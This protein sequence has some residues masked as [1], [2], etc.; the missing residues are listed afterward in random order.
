[1]GRQKQASVSPHVTSAIEYAEG[2][3]DRSIVACE[4]ARSAC[5]RFIHDL[6]RQKT[7]GFEF[8]L[9]ADAAADI[10]EVAEL[11]PHIKGEWARTGQTIK[12]EPWQQFIFVNVFGWKDA[13]GYRRFRLSYCEVG[14]K[15]AKSTITSVVG[16]YMLACDDEPGAEVYSAATNKDQA[17]IVFGDGRAMA[18]KTKGFR[19]EFGVVVNAH[20]INV[21]HTMSFFKALAADSDSLDGLNVHCALI[22]ELHAH[23]QRHVFDVL[24]SATGSRRQPLLW[25]ITTAGFNR[26]GVCYEQRSYIVK[27]LNGTIVDENV[28]GIIYTLDDDDDWQDEKN[29]PKPN[30]N[31]GV[32]VYIEDLR[33]QARRAA[34]SAAMQN[35]FLTK[36]MNVWVNADTAWMNM[37]SWKQCG[38]EIKLEELKGR[39]AVLGLDLASKKDIAAL[40]ILVLPEGDEASRE[41][42]CYCFGRWF[43]PERAIEYGTN[44]MYDGWNRD[45]YLR[46][47]PGNVIDYGV[48]EEEIIKLSS[49]LEIADVAYDPFQATQFATRMIAAGVPMIEMRATVLNFSEP[50][51]ELEKMVLDS[52]FVHDRDPALEW[53]ISNVVCHIDAKDNI[54]PRKESVE[55]KIDGAVAL[56]MC[57]G[58]WVSGQE[59]DTDKPHPSTIYDERGAFYV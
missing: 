30:P 31:L 22:D 10:C 33:K 46:T 4:H 37:V 18:N 32:S 50:M 59:E 9:D 11:F 1:M 40:A 12:L 47:T 29:W 20:S 26:A 25:I 54:Y 28:F 3:L 13:E 27:V 55:Q 45:G 8:W 39:R 58:R 42:P 51:K 38:R 52:Q 23:K 35:P 2:V 24:D 15:N 41:D 19:D 14:R 44:P 57:V 16:N 21:P 49:L 48:I 5:A 34:E 36:R 17:R 56:I 6:E 53:M 43:L 7:K